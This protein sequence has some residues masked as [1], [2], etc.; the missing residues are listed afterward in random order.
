MNNQQVTNGE[1]SLLA[2]LRALVPPRQLTPWE[3]QRVAELQANRFLALVEIEAAPVPSEVITELPR[4]QVLTVPDLPV[5]GTAQ[6][7]R[8]RWLISLAGH[9]LPARQR[10]S[11]GHEFKHVLDHPLREVVYV[12]R[13]GYS[14]HEQAERVADYFAACLWM[15]KRLVVRAWA[16]GVQRPRALAALFE[17]SQTAM[18]HRLSQLGLTEPVKRCHRT[19]FSSRPRYERAA[20]RLSTLG[21]T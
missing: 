9:E 4:L 1:R 13:G 12:D 8:G 14:V 6:W 3:Q 5:S 19:A 7:V 2:T 18:R 15:P 10:F 17:V 16:S 20:P 11:L 21:A